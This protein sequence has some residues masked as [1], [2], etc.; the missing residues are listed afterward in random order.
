MLEEYR[1]ICYSCG[2]CGYCVAQYAKWRGTYLV[3]PV[4]EKLGWLS[5]SARGRLAIARGI[6]EGKLTYTKPLVEHIF[7]CLMCNMCTQACP[8]GLDKEGVFKAMRADIIANGLEL[9]EGISMLATSL[10][11]EHNILGE[12]ENARGNWAEGLEIPDKADVVYFVGCVASYKF[13][14]IARATAKILRG[15]GVN[16]TILGAKE[17]CCG[18]RMFLSGH[19]A[20]GRG[21]A[22]HNMRRLKETGAKKIVTSCAECYRCL[23]QEYP[24][25]FGENFDFEVFHISELLVRLLEDKRISFTNEIYGKITYHDPCQLGRYSKVFEQPREVLDAIPGVDRV[26]MLRNRENSWCCG[27][28][29]GI[30][31]SFKP[32]LALDV[33][34]DVIKEAIDAG[35]EV[36]VTACPTCK[37]NIGDSIVRGT[38][39]ADVQLMDLSELAAKSLP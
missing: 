39:N 22:E 3:C 38:V 18:N 17:W 29:A 9:P 27:A 25:L 21:M 7:S 31:K 11:R 13:P 8:V 30:V 24:L 19:L 10:R 14:E 20:M 2:R 15:G 1:K 33:A 23:K 28:G 4:R 5:Y 35:A 16:F 36:I 12:P 26:E 34:D 6:L 37:W 32:D